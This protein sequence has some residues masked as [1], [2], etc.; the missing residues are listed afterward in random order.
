MYNINQS[1][2]NFLS[3]VQGIWT[4]LQKLSLG[5]E[6]AHAGRFIRRVFILSR[7]REGFGISNER[8]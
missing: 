8:I 1:W 2:R 3:N 5:L 4:I 6:G 7:K